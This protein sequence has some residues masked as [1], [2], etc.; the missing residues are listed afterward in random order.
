MSDQQFVIELGT[1]GR[2][3]VEP[4][5]GAWIEEKLRGEPTARLRLRPDDSDTE[6]HG[7]AA[8]QIRVLVDD[9]DDTEG[10][11][12]SIHFPSAAA[13][14]AFRK[15]LLVTGV[16]VGTVAV[17]AAGGAALSSLQSDTGSA[18]AA[19]TAATQ[20]GPMDVHEARALGTSGL[21]AA[22]QATADRLSGQA[23]AA[24]DSDNDE[25]GTPGR[26]GL[27]PR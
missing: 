20:A 7:F 1:D 18:G 4:R 24:S 3:T 13:A 14:A 26:G 5:D 21:S 22:D 12:I 9:E 25:A 23:A 8:T 27:T 16:L 19:G 2:A 11:A 15:R 17:G 6:G 10:H